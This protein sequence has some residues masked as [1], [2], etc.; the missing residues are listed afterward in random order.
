[1]DTREVVNL[2]TSENGIGTKWIHLVWEPPCSPAD[3]ITDSMLYSVERCDD[4]N[5][6]QTNET[7]KSHNATDL[8]PCTQY[9][10]KVK[11][12]TEVWESKGVDL[13]V[14]TDDASEC[15]IGLL[16]LK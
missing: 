12:L 4:K 9:K 11:I 10:F 16:S 2:T 8:D 13:S 6:I 5:C 15:I 3:N 1:M 14:K 7:D